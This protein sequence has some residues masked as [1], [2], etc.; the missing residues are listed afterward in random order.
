MQIRSDLPGCRKD[1]LIV[2][3]D[4]LAG[5]IPTEN[6]DFVLWPPVCAG[7][8]CRLALHLQIQR[9]VYLYF[10]SV[11][12]WFAA[13]G[14]WSGSFLS[15]ANLEK[16]VYQSITQVVSDDFARLMPWCFYR[17]VW[18]V[19][20]KGLT[21][22]LM[23]K[24]WWSSCGSDAEKISVLTC[25]VCCSSWAASCSSVLRAA[26]ASCTQPSTPTSGCCRFPW[27]AWSSQQ[28]VSSP[29]TRWSLLR[30]WAQPSAFFW[31]WSREHLRLLSPPA[32]SHR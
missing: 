2:W 27:M 29:P 28:P 32:S 1:T 8:L 24:I 20:F 16:S 23:S 22:C 21:P 17:F 4:C 26:R 13:N 14:V 6:Q 30:S 18:H 5:G 7:G 11:F 12:L 15:L 25:L 3:W 31:E 10:I 9:C 19:L